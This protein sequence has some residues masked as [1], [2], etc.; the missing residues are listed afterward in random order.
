MAVYRLNP[1]RRIQSYWH[2]RQLVNPGDLCFDIG[3]HTG[4][5]I[6]TFLALGAQVVAV[7]PLPNFMKFLNYLYKENTQVTLV[8]T[9]VTSHIGYQSF[10]I[11]TKNPTMSSLKLDWTI[12]ISQQDRFSKVIWNKEIR[13]ETTTLDM[14]I[15]EFGIP[16]FCKIDIEGAELEALTGLS[17]PLPSLSFEYIPARIDIALSCI[18]RLSGLGQ[19]K[20][21]LSL[22][23]S[24]KFIFEDWKDSSAIYETLTETKLGGPSGDIYATLQ[25]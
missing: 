21:N 14:L 15:A 23:E 10:Y 1:I 2:Y 17:R 9:A 19:Y 18:Q 12:D 13:V 16:D 5:R 8:E 25:H 4:D 7:E 6:S 22:G 3:S 24:K 20:F 11:S